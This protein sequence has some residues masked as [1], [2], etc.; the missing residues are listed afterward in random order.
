M[1]RHGGA[2]GWRRAGIAWLIFALWAG[3]ALCQDGGQRVEGTESAEAKNAAA[4]ALPEG[5][6]PHSFWDRTNVSLFA[7]IGLMRALDYTSTRNMQARGREELLIPDDV[8]NN[9]AGFAA[10]EAA[11]AMTSVG[12]SYWLHRTGHHRAER[13]L[14]I[15]HISVTGFGAARN[16]G[17]RSRHRR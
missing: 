3:T 14:S 12:L 17:L 5:P 15:G 6:R 7:G 2:R 4:P 9:S 1:A 8:A 11:G 13:W 16:Y 10:L